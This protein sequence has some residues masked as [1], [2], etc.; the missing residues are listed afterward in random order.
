MVRAQQ[1]EA[2]K[3]DL[4]QALA[5]GGGNTKD[6]QVIDAIENLQAL[7]P[8]I[9][10]TRSGTLLDGNW[11]LISAPNF[12]DG[13]Q[14]ADGSFAYTLG[15]VAFEMFQP[16]ELKLS[17]KRVLQPVFLLGNGEERSHDI[18][19][20]FTTIDQS[21]PQLA[22]IIRT[23][24]VCSPLDDTVLQVQFTGGTLAP[25]ES[26]NMAQ[27]EAVFANQ[28][29]PSGISWQEKF[30]SAIVRL[31]F[32]LVPP[33]GMNLETGEVAFSMKRC[34]TTSRFSSRRSANASTPKGRLSIIYLDEELRITRAEKGTVLVCERQY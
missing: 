19:V 5:A 1:C 2:A 33:Q 20:E 13:E 6:K 31:M 23:I 18:I 24:G 22:G 26:T 10:P 29:P 34:L 16:K 4:R 3:Q 32:G 25:Q 14:L 11:L 9:A 8:T 30:K 7:N 28:Q 12:P 15:R 17:I 21:F 27:W